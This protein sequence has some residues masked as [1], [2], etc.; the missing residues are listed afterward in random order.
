MAERLNYEVVEGKLSSFNSSCDSLYSALRDLDSIVSSTLG[1]NG[2]AIRGDIARIL[3]NEWDNNCACFL[4]FK[5][6]FEEWHTAAVDICAH[7]A[8]FE[9]ES[10]EAT[11]KVY[12][13]DTDGGSA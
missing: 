4:N 1:N 11:E 12:K 6:L 2:G 13:M 3:L 10:I 7:N 8:Q 9:Q 5:G